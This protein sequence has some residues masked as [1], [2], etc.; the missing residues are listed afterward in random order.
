MLESSPLVAEGHRSLAVEILDCTLRDGSYA[1]GFQFSESTIRRVL[2]GLERSGIQFIELGHGMGLNAGECTP[3]SIL[4]SDATS[5][6]IASE[7]LVT[8]KWGMFCIPGIAELD[9]LRQAAAAGMHFVRIGVDVSAVA[10][11]EDFLALAKDLGITAFANLMKTSVVAIDDVT[12]AVWQ[13]AEYGAD[14]VYLV[15]SAGGYLPSEVTE[16]FEKV[17]Q[18][19]A[20]PL[21][22]HG[23]NNLSLANANSLAAVESGAQFVDTTLDGIGRGAGN[24]VTETFAATL[25]AHGGRTDYD[26]RAL[27]E[28]SES[29]IRPLSRLPDHRTYQ[30]FGGVTRTHSSFFPLISRCAES[31]KV[32]VFD[33]MAAVAEVDRVHPSEDMVLETASAIIAR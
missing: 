25:Y 18:S 20:L 11:A 13:C 32:D 33:L 24:T 8:A 15:D 4:V 23:H 12:D 31:A 30:L 21:G 5:L 10:P 1:V 29:A 9:H 14:T 2:G 3:H 28:L 6:R 17:S 26:F 7:T 19:V 16:L 27:G 22:F